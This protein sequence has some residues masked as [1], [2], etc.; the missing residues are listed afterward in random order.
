[1]GKNNKGLPL[2]YGLRGDLK[3]NYKFQKI[4]NIE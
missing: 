2:I 3:R 1:M 4:N